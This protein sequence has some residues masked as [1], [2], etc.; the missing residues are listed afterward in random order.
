MNMNNALENRKCRACPGFAQY[1]IPVSPRILPR[2]RLFINWIRAVVAAL[3]VCVF[4]ALT[5]GW[6]QQPQKVAPVTVHAMDW[7]GHRGFDQF[8]DV[9]P[10][11]ILIPR[12]D[13]ARHGQIWVRTVRRF[14]NSPAIDLYIVGKVDGP[15]PDFPPTRDLIPSKE[16]VEI[17][18]AGSP[19]VEMPPLGWSHQFGQV[20]LPKGAESCEDWPKNDSFAQDVDECP[21]WVA[22]QVRYRRYFKRLFAR[23]WLLGPNDAIESF[24]TPAFKHIKDR[25]AEGFP[26]FMKPQ[27]KLQMIHFFCPEPS[28]YAFEVLIPFE[29][30][31][32]LP[33]SH[34][35]QL[36]LLVDV[37]NAVSH[38]KK[39]SVY[40]TSSPLQVWGN[41]STLNVL[42]LDPPL[43]CPLTFCDLPLGE[44]PEERKEHRTW[45]LP[46]SL[47][48][49]VGT[50]VLDDTF[51]IENMFRCGGWSPGGLSPWVR[52]TH[53]F[54]MGTRKEIGLWVCG[55]NLT[56]VKNGKSQTLAEVIG[57]KGWITSKCRTAICSSNSAHES[58]HLRALRASR[59]PGRPSLS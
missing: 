24:A 52:E 32:P 6:A 9:A 3:F 44:T 10:D 27:G 53:H 40:S 16:H 30:F 11:M 39:T 20:T 33:E 54:E 12:G 19:D 42:H 35:T 7:A 29:A 26:E 17:W 58:G 37:F 46:K 36:Y 55:P 45:V 25:Y 15:V 43:T 31:P 28:G 4:L 23:Q 59:A 13:G 18:L 48:T 51:V 47:R 5:P 50:N 21:D 56:L 8:K 14:P 2:R 34:T 22:S 1:N 38:G 49:F 41:P 57:Q